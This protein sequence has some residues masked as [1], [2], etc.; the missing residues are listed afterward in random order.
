MTPDACKRIESAVSHFPRKTGSGMKVLQ[1]DGGVMNGP[2]GRGRRWRRS[3]VAASLVLFVMWP[4]SPATAHYLNHRDLDDSRS[5]LDL[6]SVHLWQYE[7]HGL[8]SLVIR[9]YDVID[10]DETPL[11]VGWLDTFGDRE[12]DYALIIRWNSCT[13]ISWSQDPGITIFATRMDA[14]KAHCLF[15]TDDSF[16]QTKHMR[17]R[18]VARRD[19]NLNSR[20][21]LVDR[22]PDRGWF[23]H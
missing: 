2:R 4:S 9:T 21:G 17:L 6:R 11:L 12:W 16:R 23:D 19:L 18:V 15:Q 14:R 7:Q 10:R 5:S 13:V 22:A 20:R 3:A 1:K 8:Y